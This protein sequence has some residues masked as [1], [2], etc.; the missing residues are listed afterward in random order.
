MCARETLK[1]EWVSPGVQ[2]FPDEEDSLAVEDSLVVPRVW[3]LMGKNGWGAQL[4][5]L[6]LATVPSSP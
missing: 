2:D 3:I 5:C 4:W 6:S 1:G